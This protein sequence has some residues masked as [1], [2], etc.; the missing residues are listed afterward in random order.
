VDG[1]A[2]GDKACAP[3]PA[4]AG[5]QRAATGGAVG[6]RRGLA[7]LPALAL[8]FTLTSG[9]PYGLEEIVPGSGP[10]L[11]L[12]VLAAL[13]L[14]WAVPYSLVTAE[15]ASALPREGGAYRWYRAYLPSAWAIRFACLD[16]LSWVLDA[17]LYPPL[18]AAYFLRAV[19]PG[20]GPLAAWGVGLAVIWGCAA[21]NIRG[22]APAGRFA[23][24][25]TAISLAPVAVLLL[26]GLPQLSHAELGPFV[27]P[28][29]PVGTALG[30]AFVFGIWSYSGYSGLAYASE[31]IVDA[32]RTYPR[33]LAATLPLVTF[34]YVAPLVVALA[35]TPEWPAWGTGHFERVAFA[36]GG[37]GLALLV[38]VGAQCANLSLF[39]GELLITSRLPYALAQDG[40]LPPFFSRLHPRYGT[41]A[42][43][44]VIQALLYS[45][46]TAFFDFVDILTISTWIAI[47]SYLLLFVSPIL[48]RARHPELRGSFRI[49]GGWPAVG[50]CA[51]LPS[52]IALGVLATLSLR[53]LLAGL[54]VMG[55]VP[56]LSFAARRSAA[57]GARL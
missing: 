1:S 35:V 30:H 54:A 39:S 16:W 22:I 32:P 19:L 37:G 33:L 10:G 36:L 28:D 15:L 51:V 50:L 12:G 4:P 8:M 42:R 2:N 55:L 23:V 6:L 52:A 43:F 34:L 5:G 20:A 38:S 13:A 26:L 44:L 48:L 3:E 17:A 14:L 53:E 47:P 49:P 7:T 57:A 18:L 41:P 9:G 29:V 40:A 27:A 46:L 24:V 56:L 11:A 45:V 25:L 21:L 31:E